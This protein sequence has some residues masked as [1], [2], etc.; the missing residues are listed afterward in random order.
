MT[1]SR[2]GFSLLLGAASLSLTPSVFAQETAA[3]TPSAPEAGPMDAK[4]R[5]LYEAETEWRHQEFHLVKQ[6][7]RWVQGNRFPSETAE[8]QAKRGTGQRRRVPPDDLGAG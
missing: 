2:I 7:D 3:E 1:I 5:A 4:L 8:T 6:D